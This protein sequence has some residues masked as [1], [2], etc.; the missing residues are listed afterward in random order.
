MTHNNNAENKANK[1]KWWQLSLL[2][3]ACTVGTGFFLGSHLAIEVGGPAVIAAYGAAAIATYLVFD[4]LAQMTAQ[5]PMEGSF[6]SYAKQAFGRWAGFSSGWVYWSSEMLIIGSQLSALSLFSRFWFPQIPMWCFAAGYG[7]LG[8][9]IVILGTKGFE[10]LENMFAVMKIAAISM[11]ILLAIL[12]LAGVFKTHAHGAAMP[13]NWLPAGIT[14]IWAALIFVFYAYGGLEVIGLM[15][16]RLENTEEAPKA[17]KIMLIVLASVYMLSI[18]FVLMLEPW[19]SYKA[20]ESPFVVALTDYKLAFVPHLFNAVLIIA[21][22][23]TMTASLFAVTTI[24]VTLAKDADAP[25]LFAK[26][27]NENGRKPLS[28]VCLTA[29]GVSGSVLFALLMP[30]N[31]YEYMT[32]AAG[33]MLL[34]NWLFILVTS[35]RLLPRS[36]WNRTKQYTGMCLIGAAISGTLFHRISRPGFFISLGFIAVIGF[37]TWFMR[38]RWNHPLSEQNP[39]RFESKIQTESNKRHSGNDRNRGKQPVR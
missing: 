21:G 1:M 30:E 18:G 39:I 14:G 3:I 29:I 2:G 34:Y 20:N 25:P 38:R 16:V 10:R 7:L 5:Q 11:F 19:Q 36:V 28:A 8:L 15:A 24:I 13:T 26:G 17:G 27:S 31:V 9:F 22:F 33:L 23:S 6:R 12:A 32:T 37:V 35:G 4:R